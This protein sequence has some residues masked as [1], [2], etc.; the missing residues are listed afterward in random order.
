MGVMVVLNLRLLEKNY[1]AGTVEHTP[2]SSS[3]ITIAAGVG[4]F[5]SAVQVIQ[6]PSEKPP[7]TLNFFSI[8]SIATF[9]MALS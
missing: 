8:N 2:H 9:G 1:H 6:Q 7:Q 4:M 3:S 5:V